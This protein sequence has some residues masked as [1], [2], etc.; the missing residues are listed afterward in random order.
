VGRLAKRTAVARQIAPA[1]VVSQY[2]NYIRTSRTDRAASEQAPTGNPAANPQAKMSLM[3]HERIG[4]AE[5]DGSLRQGRAVGVE[6]LLR[7]VVDFFPFHSTLLVTTVLRISACTNLPLPRYGRNR[8]VHPTIATGLCCACL[9]C[10]SA[11]WLTMLPRLAQAQPS[12]PDLEAARANF[13]TELLRLEQVCVSLTLTDQARMTRDW[14]PRPPGHGELLYLPQSPAVVK[15]DNPAQ[16]K[17]ADYFRAARAKYAQA[18]FEEARRLAQSGEEAAAFR[19][20]WQVLREDEQHAEAKRVLGTLATAATVRPR[21]RKGTTPHPTYGWPAGTYSRIET[22]HF[23]LTTRG[24]P[25]ESV[26]LAQ[27]MERY[28]ALWRQVFYPLWATPGAL[29]NKLEGRNTPWEKSHQLSVTLLKDRDEYLQVLGIAEK[30]AAVSVGYYA[31]QA[32][33]SF[34]YMAENHEATLVHELTHQLFAEATKID[35]RAEAGN[36]TG[37]WLMEGIALYME[38]L[39]DRGTYWTLGGIDAPRL[40]TARYRAVRDGYWADWSTFTRGTVESW[41]QDPQI[42]L[43]YTQATGL[44]HLFM[45][46]LPQ[47]A[48]REALL[49]CLVG[50]YQHQADFEPLLR[51]LGG[52]E[53][54]ISTAYQRSITLNDA[55]LQALSQARHPCQELVLA[56]S[57]L[58]PTS[59]QALS[60][61][62]KELEWLDVSFSNARS[63]DLTWLPQATKLRRLSVEGTGCDAAL[64]RTLRQLPELE[65]LDLSGCPIDDAA[66]QALAPHPGLVTLWLSHTQVTE[67]VLDTLATLPKLQFCY[68]DGSKIPA[69]AWEKFAREHLKG[70]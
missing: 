61:V 44:T 21:L 52:S 48:G 35:A 36:L 38:S 12:E 24:T 13:Q 69:A 8:S 27:C 60:T 14:L 32:K 33:M 17:W 45:E 42:A 53:T 29:V 41:K 56:G 3:Y 43:L 49:Q 15:P 46:R 1:Q 57:Q 63:A 11:S 22:P 66:L 51:M 68:V 47:P 18:L 30:N 9:W 31:P 39:T 37:V 26:E 16:A 55:D 10:L 70:N 20:L 6:R 34:F 62:A 50:V 7:I 40:Q 28:Y 65:E 54:E 67:A 2:K 19:T 58:T 64:L 5:I 23:L 59:W 25:Q 4:S